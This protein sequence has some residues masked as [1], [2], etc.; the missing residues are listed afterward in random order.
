[1]LLNKRKTAVST[2]FLGLLL[3]LSMAGFSFAHWYDYIYVDATV[4]TGTVCAEW[5]A[6]VTY[7]DHGDDWTCDVGTMKNVHQIDKDIGS[8]LFDL[9][10]TDADGTYDTLE[11]TLNNV[12][13]CYYEHASSWIHNCG[14]IPWRI[15]KVTF[16]TSTGTVVLTTFGYFTLDLDG[17]GLD[18]VE[19]RWGD[20]FGAQVDPCE[21]VD[22]SFSIHVL[23][24]APQDTQ[25]S[26]TAEVEV[27]NW[28]EAPP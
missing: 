12:Y 2:I 1:M 15:S 19:C 28:N 17:D 25:M 22:I 7:T 27:Y 24:N 21:S 14:T 10:D 26:F 11:M 13:P 3:T 16:T 23:Q 4:H 5:E 9:K 20:N 6:P 18:D 8:S